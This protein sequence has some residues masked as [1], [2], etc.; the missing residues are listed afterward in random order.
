MKALKIVAVVLGVLLLLGGIGLLAGSAAVGFG[1]GAFEDE[2]AKSG[3]AGPVRGTVTSIE[4]GLYTVSYTDKQ[5]VSQTGQG[6]SGQRH[7]GAA[8]GCRGGRLLQHQRPEPDRDLEHPR[9]RPGRDRRWSADD[10]HRL[11]GGRRDPAA[12]RDHRPGRRAQE[13]GRGRADVPDSVAPGAGVP[14]TARPATTRLFAATSTRFSALSAAA[15]PA[16]AGLPAAT[17]PV[18]GGLPAAAGP[19]PDTRSNRARRL[20]TRSN[21]DSLPTADS[22]A[23]FDSRAGLPIL[24]ACSARIRRAVRASEIR[25]RLESAQG[26]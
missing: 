25:P 7:R 14:R 9:R 5:G 11:P 16:A 6:P 22:N 3:L 17:G 4:S 13:G 23:A 21:S 12:R 18:A 15:V 10:G 20:D 8:G 24:P 19:S 2:L 26:L 1:Q